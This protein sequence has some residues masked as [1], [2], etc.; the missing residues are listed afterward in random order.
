MRAG[1]AFGV[2]VTVDDLNSTVISDS[3]L[4]DPMFTT[5]RK[6][7][8]LYV[9]GRNFE[10]AYIPFVAR[11]KTFEKTGRHL[12]RFIKPTGATF[13]FVAQDQ[14]DSLAVVTEF[15]SEARLFEEPPILKECRA[16]HP[17]LHNIAPRD[18][19][20]DIWT[21]AAWLADAHQNDP[22]FAVYRD[23]ALCF[24]ASFLP[25]VGLRDPTKGP[26]ESTMFL[27]RYRIPRYLN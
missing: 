1:A 15:M 6:L 10:S 11:N 7:L 9:E 21:T 23:A 26:V 4:P 18:I 14:H 19:A 5:A 8:L 16:S 24:W 2:P 3:I 25:P 17:I 27:P 22:E 13:N 12:W 20:P